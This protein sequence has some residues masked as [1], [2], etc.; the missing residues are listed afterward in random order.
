MKFLVKSATRQ[1]AGRTKGNIYDF[2]RKSGYSFQKENKERGELIFIRRLGARD[3]PRFHL[4]L[5]TDKSSDNIIFDLHL[6]QR[7]PVYRGTPAHLAEYNG[8]AVKQ[9]VERIKK[10]ILGGPVV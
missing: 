9:E 7:K 8:E 3:Y 4:Y 6:D 2:M 5:K 1:L 10:N